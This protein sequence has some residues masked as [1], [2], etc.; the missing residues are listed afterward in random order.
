MNVLI[1]LIRDRRAA[2]AGPSLAEQVGNMAISNF[3]QQ[4]SRERGRALGKK[5]VD[6]DEEYVQSPVE[7]TMLSLM[8]K[9]I[10]EDKKNRQEMAD[11]YDRLL[12]QIH[13]AKEKSNEEIDGIKKN[14]IDASYRTESPNAPDESEQPQ[15]EEPI[16]PE[17]AAEGV[18][19]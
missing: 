3:A 8:T 10:E 18:Q 12:A 9:Q 1:E 13:E 15:H 5:L 6:P 7:Q 17:Q 4:L 14:V 16:V 19:Q 11:R 2:R